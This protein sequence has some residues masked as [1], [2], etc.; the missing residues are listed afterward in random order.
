MSFPVPTHTA[1]WSPLAIN[2]GVLRI[3]SSAGLSLLER[4]RWWPSFRWEICA[5]DFPL[6]LISLLQ[7][8]VLTYFHPGGNH[9]ISWC[10]YQRD[11]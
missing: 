7:S 9:L 5:M 2:D 6:S 3:L 4:S 1:D 10:A 11:S 8:L